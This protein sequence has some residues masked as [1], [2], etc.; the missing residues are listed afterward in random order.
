MVSYFVTSHSLI[1]NTGYSFHKKIDDSNW[2]MYQVLSFF[3]FDFI[4]SVCPMYRDTNNIHVVS[5]R[6]HTENLSK[7]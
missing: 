7:F 2:Y 1:Q 6:L 5:A 4:G 3:Q